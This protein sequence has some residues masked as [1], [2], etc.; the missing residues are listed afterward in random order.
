MDAR[1]AHLI[2]SANRWEMCAEMKRL[3]SGGTT[4]IVDRYV[5]SGIA[6]SVAKVRHTCTFINA[7]SHISAGH[8]S[9]VVPRT[10]C[11]ST[12]TRCHSIHIRITRH[13]QGSH[14]GTVRRRTIREYAIPTKGLTHTM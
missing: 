3:M 6:Y 2:F 5:H 13:D 11:G 1:S 8:R 7:H 4:L 14:D 12:T 10:R 9:R